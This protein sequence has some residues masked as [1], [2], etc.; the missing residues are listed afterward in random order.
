MLYWGRKHH[1]CAG[2][3]VQQHR[4]WRG[5][6]LQ[7]ELPNFLNPSWSLYPAL[8]VPSSC[9]LLKAGVC[10]SIW[11]GN[12]LPGPHAQLMFFWSIVLELAGWQGCTR[13]GC[14]HLPSCCIFSNLTIS[15]RRVKVM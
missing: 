8:V 6:L 13:T 4:G 14:L 5:S 10:S 1:L 11:V 12:Q 2:D 3:L 9:S 7:E 15:H